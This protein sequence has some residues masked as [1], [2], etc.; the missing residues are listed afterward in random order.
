MHPQGHG[1]SLTSLGIL[2][3]EIPPMFFSITQNIYH[4]PSSN[5]TRILSLVAHQLEN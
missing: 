5:G 4:N 1:I 2:V 3:W